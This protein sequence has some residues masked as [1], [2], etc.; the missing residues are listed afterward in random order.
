MRAST[1]KIIAEYDRL[2]FKT[3]WLSQLGVF[4]ILVF[5]FADL[6]RVF[7]LVYLDLN[8]LYTSA[9]QVVKTII[10]YLLMITAFGFR[11]IKLFSRRETASGYMYVSWWV[12]LAAAFLYYADAKN[13]W[14]N[15]FGIFSFQSDPLES[16]WI[17]FLIWSGIRFFITMVISFIR[18]VRS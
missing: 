5:A 1:E 8:I 6:F 15:D 16:I 13:Y 18:S 3:K 2:M 10:F 9:F 7:M 12:P 17:T 4:L 11:F 14:Q